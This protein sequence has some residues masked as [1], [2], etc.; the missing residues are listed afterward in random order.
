MKSKREAA[1]VCIDFAFVF[2]FP[3]LKF[4]TSDEIPMDSERRKT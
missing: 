1:N 3:S 2:A 4:Q